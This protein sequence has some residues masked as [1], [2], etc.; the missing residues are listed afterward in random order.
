MKREDKVTLRSFLIELLVYAALVFGYYL[1]VLHFLGGW[2]NHLFTTDRRLYA[3]VAL[4][5]IICQGV[6]LEA[7]TRGLL[8]WIKPRR[9]GA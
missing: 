9:E 4:V 8:A 1:L 3:A 7:L 6:L 5:F 2:L